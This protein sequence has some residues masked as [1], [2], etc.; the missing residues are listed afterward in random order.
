M[1]CYNLYGLCGKSER[2]R[3]KEKTEMAKKNQ[4]SLIKNPFY[5]LNSYTETNKH[6]SNST[7]FDTF[8]QTHCKNY[9][10]YRVI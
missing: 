1:C 7:T 2:E 9:C 10:V 8:G 3:E 6:V 5:K 4:F